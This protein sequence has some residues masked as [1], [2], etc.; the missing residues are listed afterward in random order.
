MRLAGWPRF[1]WLLRRGR[2]RRNSHTYSGLL[3]TRAVEACQNAQGPMRS[4]SP[5]LPYPDCTTFY[6]LWFA[7]FYQPISSEAAV[8][9]SSPR[10][11]LKSL[12]LTDRDLPVTLSETIS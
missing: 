9:V 11:L 4:A 6:H 8:S 10:C 1:I 2:G 7:L 12:L 5:H 3:L